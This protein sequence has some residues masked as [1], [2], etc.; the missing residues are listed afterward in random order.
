[1][2]HVKIFNCTVLMK[3]ILLIIVSKNLAL[4][5]NAST[6]VPNISP[7]YTSLGS[8]CNIAKFSV[9]AQHFVFRC[10]IICETQSYSYLIFCVR[11]VPYVKRNI[12]ITMLFQK[13]CQAGHYTH[14]N[15]VYWMM[16]QENS[17]TSQIMSSCVWRYSNLVNF[18]YLLYYQFQ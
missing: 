1:M 9:S 15:S 13:L 17:A 14:M 12:Y 8:L 5:S 3:V 2:L 18:N 6:E 7:N 11:N 10:K 4:H 16:E